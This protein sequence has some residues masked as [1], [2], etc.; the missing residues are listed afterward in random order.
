MKRTLTQELYHL[1]GRLE[2]NKLKVTMLEKDL[3]LEK[4]ARLL[5]ETQ[6]EVSFN[7]RDLARKEIVPLNCL[8]KKLFNESETIKKLVNNGI[9]DNKNN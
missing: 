1:R 6:L 3:L 8:I 9:V 2:D 5:S 4:D 7:Q